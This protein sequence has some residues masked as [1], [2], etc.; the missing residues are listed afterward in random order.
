[1]K[2][3]NLLPENYPDGNPKLFIDNIF[4]RLTINDFND[5]NKTKHSQMEQ[6]A[7]SIVQLLDYL[8][9]QFEYIVMK[10]MPHK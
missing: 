6:V 7:I 4:A 10:N 3:K 5:L 8:D 2:S 9:G 1:M